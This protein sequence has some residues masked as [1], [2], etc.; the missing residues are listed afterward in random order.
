MGWG[1][2]CC[3]DLVGLRTAIQ[4]GLPGLLHLAQVGRDSAPATRFLRDGSDDARIGQF[5]SRVGYA[6]FRGANAKVFDSRRRGW[7]QDGRSF[8]SLAFSNED[9][10]SLE[11]MVPSFFVCDGRNLERIHGADLPGLPNDEVIDR[12]LRDPNRLRQPAIPGIRY[13]MTPGHRQGV[14]RAVQAGADAPEVWENDIAG[15]VAVYFVNG[16]LLDEAYRGPSLDLPMGEAL[17]NTVLSNWDA[18]P[19]V[20][21]R[22]TGCLHRV[23]A[24]DNG[25]IMRLASYSN[26]AFVLSDD[27]WDVLTGRTRLA[28]PAE[29]PTTF[30]GASLLTWEEWESLVRMAQPT[31]QPAPG[32]EAASARRSTWEESELHNAESTYPTDDL[33]RA[34]VDLQRGFVDFR[35]TGS[36][37]YEVLCQS[38]QQVGSQRTARLK[39]ADFFLQLSIGDPSKVT[40]SV[41]EALHEAL[42]DVNTAVGVDIAQTLG[43]LARRGS[44]RVLADFVDAGANGSQWASEAARVALLMDRRL[45]KAYYLKRFGMITPNTRTEA[46]FAELLRILRPS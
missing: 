12:L 17:L 9:F 2:F 13:P 25:A 24:L 16:V 34:I 32:G 11:T 38:G 45:F 4:A 37:D 28:D 14:I 36:R 44:I 18:N 19:D 39:A 40:I 7:H 46:D 5:Y 1:R 30:D 10:E 3:F 26:S 22:Y 31:G 6:F 43:F 23:A 21:Q 15:D 35:E 41:L 29:S 33:T 20:A 27:D 8:F 42:F